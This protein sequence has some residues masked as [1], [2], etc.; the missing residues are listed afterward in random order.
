[1]EIKILS[2]SDVNEN[3]VN[4]F[5]NKEIVRYSDNQYRSFSLEGQRLYVESC[6]NN[7]EIRLF[8]IFID[9]MHIGN[10]LLNGIGS[11]HKRAELTYVIGEKKYWGQGIASNAIATIIEIS[12]KDYNLKK[13]FAGIAK[14]NIGSK[15]VLE[16]NGF[17]LE[18]IRKKHLYYNNVF[19]D[20]L[21]YGLIL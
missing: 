11:I 6:F 20:Q 17:E 13:L 2:P 10:I 9:E 3:Y 12:K 4:W 18:G 16:K 21:D 1:M 14:N 8:G 5:S 19:E 7:N 15:K